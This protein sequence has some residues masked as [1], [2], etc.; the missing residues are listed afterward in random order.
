MDRTTWNALVNA[1]AP[2]FGAFLQ[3]WEWGMFQ[4][5]LG[6]KVERIHIE[7][8]RGVMLAQAVRLDLPFGWSYWQ[9]PKG[10]LGT[11]PVADMMKE[12]SG[13]FPHGAFVRVEPKEAPR[14]LH[15]R[16]VQPAVTA[17]LDLTQ[18]MDKLLANMK[19]KM[20]YNIRLAEKKGVTARFAGHDAIDDLA[21]LLEQTATRDKFHLHPIAY[22]EAMLGA[23]SGGD[24][25]AT[26]AFA[27]FEGRPLAANI[28]IDCNGQ[29]TYLH[30][31][32]SNLHRNLQ[33]PSF[34][35]RFL[36]QDAIAAGMTSY[37]FWGVAPVGARKGH[38][39]AGVTQFKL[40]F[41][42]E[43]VAMPGTYDIPLSMPVYALYRGSKLVQGIRRGLRL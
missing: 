22:Y 11:M 7:D 13:H 10:P 40:G 9:I 6:R 38:R 8:E 37:D 32:S 24:V 18:G 33:A 28:S 3:S 26:L 39:W 2:R 25:R 12:L 29:R 27:E 34:L 43:I 1:H 16:E 35:H 20:R 23:L 19:P 5:S 31:A 41:G 15:V 21:R 30:G 42:G 14:G 36:I 17:I 4:E